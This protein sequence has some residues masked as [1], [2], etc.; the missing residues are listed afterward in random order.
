VVRKLNPDAKMVRFTQLRW[1][2]IFVG[3]SSRL[4]SAVLDH[5]GIKKDFFTVLMY[6]QVRNLIHMLTEGDLGRDCVLNRR[7]MGSISLYAR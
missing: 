2:A 4:L 3:D 1:N 6:T 7:R 5:L